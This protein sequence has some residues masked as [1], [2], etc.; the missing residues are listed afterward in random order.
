MVAL[1]FRTFG[2]IETDREHVPWNTHSTNLRLCLFPWSKTC[3]C[4]RVAPVFR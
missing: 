2:I 3:R 1:A 4:Q